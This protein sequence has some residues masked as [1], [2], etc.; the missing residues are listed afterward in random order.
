MKEGKRMKQ[1]NAN[2]INQILE[3][4]ISKQNE[5]TTGIKSKFQ[6]I[7]NIEENI[8]KFP[9]EDIDKAVVKSI[10]KQALKEYEKGNIVFSI[11][12]TKISSK[13]KIE[14]M[15]EAFDAY[16]IVALETENNVIFQIYDERLL[17]SLHNRAIVSDK[18]E[19]AIEKLILQLTSDIMLK[20]SLGERIELKLVDTITVTN[21]YTNKEDEVS[22]MLFTINEVGTLMSLLDEKYNVILSEHNLVIDG[23]I[24]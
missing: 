14:G 10:V 3:N 18:R 12:D 7:T 13:Y 24:Y 19:E 23:I 16:G 1:N 11:L 15:K 8:E 6:I 9:K 20:I 21:S 17:H 4:K 5:A 2:I 22:V